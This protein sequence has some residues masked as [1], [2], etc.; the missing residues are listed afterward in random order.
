M[1]RCESAAEAGAYI[2][3][4]SAGRS[5]GNEITRG[6]LKT[7]RAGHRTPWQVLED[8]RQAGDL[9]DLQL[10]REYERATKGH[11]CVT[12]SKGLKRGLAVAS[13]LIRMHHPPL[14]VTAI[15]PESVCVSGIVAVQA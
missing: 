4:T 14:V 12:W 7:G 1:E 15:A 6:D 2:A 10:W 13:Q 3:K 8:F 11:Q 5:V 9:A